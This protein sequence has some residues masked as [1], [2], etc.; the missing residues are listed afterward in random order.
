MQR[1]GIF[2]VSKLISGIHKLAKIILAFCR[3]VERLGRNW[4]EFVAL[5]L[6]VVGHLVMAIYHEPWYDEAVAWQI[7]RCASVKDILFEIPHYEGHPPLWHLV[8][9]PFAKLGAPYELSLS[10]VSLLFTGTAVALILWK[11]PF[12]RLVRL[13]IPF[14][15]FFFYQYS[16]ISRPYAMM[17][18]AFVLL[19]MAYP[20]RNEKPGRYTLG[21]MFL[22]LT[23]AYGIVLAGGLAM[24]WVWEIW[25]KQ[26]ILQWFK[27]FLHDQRILW[28][29]G[30]LALAIFLILGIM[31]REDTFA[32]KNI[33]GAVGKNPWGIRLLYTFIALPSEVLYTSV[34]SQY[35]YLQNAD[36]FENGFALAIILGLILWG[37]LIYCSSK[38]KLSALLLVPHFLFSTFSA[39][40]YMCIHHTGIVLLF[41]LFW[42]WVYSMSSPPSHSLSVFQPQ[43]KDCI[44]VLIAMAIVIGFYWTSSVVIHDVNKNY[45]PG[46]SI[47]AFIH[48]HHLDQYNILCQWT[49]KY[50]TDGVVQKVDTKYSDYADPVSPYFSS[51]IF[52]NI[53]N[54]SNRSN[55]SSH[56]VATEADNISNLALWK[57]K[58]YPDVLYMYPELSL[59]W[60]PYELSYEDYAVVHKSIAS[61]LWKSHCFPSSYHIFVRRDLLNALEL[62]DLGPLVIVRGQ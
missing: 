45:D 10:F 19:A 7:A 8:L 52:Y 27:S 42:V 58:G 54:G 4:P 11:S 44:S 49:V 35:T 43:I 57:S 30:L 47:A 50:S 55:Y 26:N 40:I 22:C 25:N 16:V 13:L 60:A 21:L 34:Y 32:V 5:A 20:T 2:M 51:N 24:V 1:E 23:S 6:Y 59:L 36:L 18:L 41:Y 48:T 38:K 56:I 15:Y 61:R 39:S 46:R 9:L 53:A 62:E 12:P 28:L 29:A 14:T 17:M 3:L 37:I 31:P 33:V